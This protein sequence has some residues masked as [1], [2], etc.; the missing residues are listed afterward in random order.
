MRKQLTDLRNK[1]NELGI[2]IYIVSDKDEHLSEYTGAHFCALKEFSGFTGGDGTLVVSR[3]EAALWTDGRYF[4]QAEKELSGQGIELMKMGEKGTPSV[5]S[6]ISESLP[7][8]K[9]PA[10]EDGPAAGA[11]PADGTK[12]MG[13]G[14]LGFDG[15]CTSYMDGFN[16]CRVL[17]N[18]T[19]AMTDKDVCGLVWEDRPE[20]DCSECFILDEKYT[21]RS[22]ESK[23]AD[24]K[25]AFLKLGAK[26]HVIS[27]LDD[28][29]WLLNVRGADI[30]NNPVFMAYMIITP[31]RSVLYSD[32]RHF[33]DEL[34]RYL[35]GLGVELK[36]YHDI[37]E[38]IKT[39]QSPVLID[40]KRCSYELCNSIPAG[41]R[42]IDRMNP[43]MA[44]K[45][46]KNSVEAAN[47]RIAQHKD[48]LAVTRFIYWFKKSLGL[49][50]AGIE[51]TGGV[52]DATAAKP[53]AAAQP[54]VTAKPAVH[55]TEWECVEKLHE[56]RAE[57]EHFLDESFS[58]ISAYGA[59]AAMAHYMPSPEHVVNIEPHGLYLVDSGGQYL[60][61]T[62]D[63]TR[64]IACGELTA[65]EREAFT[66]AVIANLRLA[67]A[68]FLEGVSGLVLDYAAREPFWR[69]GMNFNHGTGHGVG[70]CLNVHEGPVGIRYKAQT[71]E[72][73]YPMMEGMYVSDEPGYYEGGSFGV[74]IENMLLAVRDYENEYGTFLK[75]E[76]MTLVPID[77]DCLDLSL[78]TDDDI[79]LLNEYHERV[80]S[81]LAGEL[82]GDPGELTG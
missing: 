10:D 60:E 81:E 62:T 33:N 37:F 38:D 47:I 14:R 59:N 35:A 79:R 26:T 15:K 9:R 75:F 51:E 44:E 12:P 66:L 55:L 39:V 73:A 31:E 61:G 46:R 48:S 19:E 68:R 4:I 76:T 82:A 41:S 78:M 43:V 32:S 29:A 56:L 2:D 5:Q 53:T 17:K 52:T 74:R 6:W 28:I 58:T 40:R 72:G 50:K 45:C 24:L 69:R 80:Y 70:F 67:D 65:K 11:K 57:G 54:I 49:V 27:S 22:A 42:I 16:F 8:G 77:K 63:I 3:D 13:P 23:L 64:T 1:M 25:T 18:G 71:M 30:P 20:E 36:G 21:G 34:R 7:E